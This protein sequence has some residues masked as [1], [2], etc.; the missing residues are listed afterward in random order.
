MDDDLNTN[1]PRP[2][3]GN[4][5]WAINGGSTLNGWID[6]FRLSKGIARWTE[7][8]TAPTV[9]YTNPSQG[10]VGGY[11]RMVRYMC[12]PWITDATTAR[13]YKYLNR[14]VNPLRV[15]EII[16]VDHRDRN[17]ACLNVR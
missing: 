10:Y 11:G 3:S 15:I 1:N 6:E 4:T 16:V 8:F 5:D 9:A 17:H 12:A 2:C 7:N 13:N 14:T